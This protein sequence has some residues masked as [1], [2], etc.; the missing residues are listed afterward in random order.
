M[1]FGLDRLLTS[2]VTT[3]CLHTTDYPVTCEVVPCSGVHLILILFAD[4]V[5][6]R[7]SRRHMVGVLELVLHLLFSVSF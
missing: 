7:A 4:E 3:V 1:D 2:N 5:L 6:G